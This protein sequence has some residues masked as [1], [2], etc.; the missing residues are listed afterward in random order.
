MAFGGSFASHVRRLDP[1]KRGRA[2]YGTLDGH[3]VMVVTSEVPLG[4]KEVPRTTF[5]VQ[6]A[7][8][9]FMQLL[10]YPRRTAAFMF[11]NPVEPL[12]GL[13]TGDDAWDTVYMVTAAEE[14]RV[15]ML[16]SPALLSSLKDVLTRSTGGARELAIND[17]MVGVTFEGTPLHTP[18]VQRVLGGLIA[19]GAALSAQARQ[20]APAPVLARLSNEW[21]AFA[22]DRHLS[23]VPERMHMRGV[24]PT[25]SLDVVLEPTPRCVYVAVTARLASTLDVAFELHEG[26][27]GWLARKLDHGITTGDADIDEHYVVHADATP[28]VREI[29]QLPAVHALLLH[30][31]SEVSLSSSHVFLRVAGLD[32]T[33]AVEQVTAAAHAIMGTDVR[34][35]DRPYR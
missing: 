19:C 30:H 20:I 33:V 26:H 34:A 35:I 24:F 27:M 10:V 29:L 23:F 1:S 8:P 18:F 11:R 9:L 14:E 31:D 3:E 32:P 17:T 4:A 5:V 7:S 21:G 22:S 12:L 2:L 15:R 6:L 16:L 28:R 13:L 25:W